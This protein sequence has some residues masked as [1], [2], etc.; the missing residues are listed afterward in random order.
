MTGL[1]LW[2]AYALYA[3]IV[4]RLR[5][6]AFTTLTGINPGTD[7][8]RLGC[9]ILLGAPLA[10]VHA[11]WRGLLIMP[12]IFIGLLL[13]GWGPFQGMGTEDVPGYV[14]ETS[15]LRWL[16]QRL[17]LAP[18]SYWHDWLGMTQAGVVCLAPSAVV[19]AW[20]AHWATVPWVMVLA[21]GAAFGEAYTLARAGLPTIPKF[22][23]GQAWGEIFAGVLVGASIGAVFFIH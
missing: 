14:P 19:V 22:V 16:P 23:T 21:C 8:A 12:A 11:E 13:S 1:W 4:W 17:G 6:G 10:L 7:G 9:G 15:W 2:S 18:G 20:V 3:G 5:G